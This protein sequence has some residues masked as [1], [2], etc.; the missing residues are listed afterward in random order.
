MQ[1]STQSRIEVIDVLRGFTLIGIAII[2]FAE[3]FYAVLIRSRTVILISNFW[4]MR[5]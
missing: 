3:Q 1:A 4:V 5:L 2:H